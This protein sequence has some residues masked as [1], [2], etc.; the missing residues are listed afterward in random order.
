MWED[1]RG[2]GTRTPAPQPHAEV[3]GS[4]AVVLAGLVAILAV[5]L[6]VVYTAR[7]PAAAGY[8]PELGISAGPPIPSVPARDRSRTSYAVAPP[9]EIDIPAIDVR[10]RLVGLRKDRDGA[11]Q[12]PE[13]P[14]RAGWYRQGFAPG[15]DGPAVIT[16]HVDS[17]V[18]PGVFARLEDMQPGQLIHV[19][20]ADGTVATFAVNAVGTFRKS[21]FP[22]ERVYVGDGQPGLRLVTCGGAFDEDARSYVD[23]V[24]VFATPVPVPVPV[25][26]QS[27]FRAGTTT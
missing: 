1:H 10:T 2:A 6:S 24:V 11:L 4:Q 5:A 22:T 13:D 18:G 8:S 3:A 9:V 21:E 19:R 12:V 16:G 17:Y 7:T 20:R 14:Q 15:E 26:V 25:L 27:P 23:N